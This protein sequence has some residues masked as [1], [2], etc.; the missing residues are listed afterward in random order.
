MKACLTAL[1]LCVACFLFQAGAAEP[2]E[3]ERKRFLETKVKAEKGD[4]K[5]QTLLGDIMYGNGEGVD[6]DYVEAVKW[7]RKAADQGHAGAQVNLG[8]RSDER[9]VGKECG[10]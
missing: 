5:A 1:Y 8:L 7:Y 2:T 3:A 6:K 4:A 10:V 9:R